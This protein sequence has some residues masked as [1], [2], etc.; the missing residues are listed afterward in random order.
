MPHQGNLMTEPA[1]SAAGAFAGHKVLVFGLPVVISL[2]AWWL[3]MRFVPVRKG[4]EAKDMLDRFLA[5]GASSF[6][7]GLPMLLVLL[8]QAPWVFSG[9]T[10]LAA[11]AG[12]E[13]ITGFLSVVGCVLLLCSLPGPWLVAAYLRW[14]H[15]RRGKDIAEMAADAADGVRKVREG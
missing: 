5:C 12:L 8:K 13:P 4:H 10:E 3:G 7:V 2:A 11:M 14:F 6:V 9:A 1:S 15:R